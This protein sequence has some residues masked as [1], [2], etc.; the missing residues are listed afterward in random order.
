MKAEVARVLQFE[1]TNAELVSA[2]TVH[3]NEIASLQKIINNLQKELANSKTENDRYVEEII[4]VKS[5]QAN[6]LDE[7]Q[8]LNS[9]LVLKEQILDKERARLEE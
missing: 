7:M 5:T 9:E 4:K 6:Q 8:R 2:Q 3:K 1:K